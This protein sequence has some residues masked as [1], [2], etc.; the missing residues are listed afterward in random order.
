[1]TLSR[2]IS[3][4]RVSGRTGLLLVLSFLLLV[5]LSPCSRAQDKHSKGSLD[6]FKNNKIRAAYV[7][8][9]DMSSLPRIAQTGLNLALVKLPLH[10]PALP[11]EIE[12]IR[13]WAQLCQDYNVR[14]MPVINLWGGVEQTNVR[15]RYKYT[16]PETGPINAPCLLDEQVFKRLVTDRIAFLANLS[17]L[18]P[19]AGVVLDNELYDARLYNVGVSLHLKPCLCDYCFGK[20]IAENPLTQPIPIQK[21]QKYLQ[22]TGQVGEYTVFYQKL[23]TNRARAVRDKIALINTDFILGCC[24]VDWPNTIAAWLADGLSDANK[25]V[26]AFSER[27]YSEGYSPYILSAQREFEKNHITAMFVPGINASEFDPEHFAPQCYYCAKDSAGY[28]IYGLLA[29]M[30]NYKS[31]PD[32]WSAIKAVNS[33]LDRYISNPNYNSAFQIQPYFHPAPQLQTTDFSFPSLKKVRFGTVEPLSPKDV[34]FHVRGK[35]TL[36]FDTSAEKEVSFE[37]SCVRLGSYR[38][39]ARIVVADFKG[40]QFNNL[41]LMP[42]Q[43]KKVAFFAPQSGLYF[44]VVDCGMNCVDILPLS[45]GYAFDATKDMHFVGEVKPLYL[46]LPKG[47]TEGKVK[48]SADGPQESFRAVFYDDS[49]VLTDLVVERQNEFAY[50]KLESN[51]DGKEVRLEIKKLPNISIEDVSLAIVSGFSPCITPFQNKLFEQPTII[52]H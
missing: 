3:I 8:A 11:E 24:N 38:D 26:L 30:H 52:S 2:K 47:V 46:W 6:F 28:W 31:G 49:R 34:K 35:N 1:V 45:E 15:Y 41:E 50:I 12:T 43:S 18:V 14:F 17:L 36:V 9:K 16:L 48:L 4:H 39:S 19:I 7:G 13:R 10:V 22:Q 42:G 44:V 20:F 29:A 23:V 32:Y 27:T 5:A 21:R 40:R 25:P 33:E 37:F 51:P